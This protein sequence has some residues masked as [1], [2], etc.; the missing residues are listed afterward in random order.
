M[1]HLL[2]LL[3]IFIAA[4]ADQSV[5]ERDVALMG[6]NLHITLDEA[7]RNRALHQ[8]EEWIQIVEDAEQELSN[9]RET[10]EIS[11]FNRNPI[12]EPFQ[13]SQNLCR[14]LPEVQM[15]VTKTDGAFDPGVGN[16]LK[17]YGFY[18]RG[19][20]PGASEIQKTLSKTGLAKIEINQQMCT[21]IRKTDVV[22]DCGAFGKGEALQRILVNAQ[23]NHSVPFQINFGG[24]VLVYGKEAEIEL[25]DP[26]ERLIGSG[27][28]IQIKSG[29]ISTSGGSERDKVVDGKRIG[30]I[31]DPH[32]GLPSPSFG[33]VTVWNENALVA[34]ILGTALYVMGPEKGMTYANANAIAAC[35]LVINDKKFVA[36][37]SNRWNDLF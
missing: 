1:K 21:A 34:D 2:F 14:L 5:L 30:H 8:S 18:D 31:L 24:Q 11:K 28:R 13:L 19:R 22:V 29:S 27:I 26:A 17:L 15:W 7:D 9:W 3:L 4:N 32:T 23:A 10:S 37:K 12:G 20:I 25:A 6:T 16:L 35:F 36:L 33:S